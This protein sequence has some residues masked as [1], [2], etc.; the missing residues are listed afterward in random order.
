MMIL[1]AAAYT[2]AALALLTG[3]AV[4]AANPVLGSTNRADRNGWPQPTGDNAPNTFILL[5]LTEIEASKGS[6]NIK[7]DWYS[8]SGGDV[9]RLWVKTEGTQRI[10]SRGS[11]DPEA[12][13]LYGRLISPFF[14]AQA[15]VRVRYRS[16]P[17]KNLVRTYASLGLQGIA[18]Y[19]YELEPTVF[20]S[21]RG[22]ISA[23]VRATYNQ[24][25]TQRL[26]LQP[27]FEF[28]VAA[29]RDRALGVGSGLNDTELGVRLR[30]EVRREFAPYLGVTW[31]QSYGETRNLARAEGEPTG[32]VSA[33]AGI[34]MWF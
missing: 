7:W 2:M 1:R 25:L 4:H 20:I 8:W 12:Q 10:S 32:Q 27:R 6:A 3:G 31:K 11:G 16:G 14:D 18:P 19:R 30:Y 9:N 24:L 13:I 33:V 23:R 22:Q 5:D 29:Q 17:G 26:I 28:N 15:G 34:R 21:D